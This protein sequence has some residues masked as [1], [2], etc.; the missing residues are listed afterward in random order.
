MF[1]GVPSKFSKCFHEQEGFQPVAAFQIIFTWT[2]PL[3]LS[4]LASLLQPSRFPIKDNNSTGNEEPKLLWLLKRGNTWEILVVCSRWSNKKEG[5]CWTLPNFVNLRWGAPLS[6]LVAVGWVFVCFWP[7]KAARNEEGLFS[8][9]ESA[10]YSD[11]ESRP[12]LVK[13]KVGPV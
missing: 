2:K 10:K 12:S 8:E 7:R 9:S 13:L 3:F 5:G 4:W 11:P 6:R 1:I